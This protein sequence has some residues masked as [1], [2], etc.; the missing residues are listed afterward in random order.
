ML[1][2]TRDGSLYVSRF[3]KCGVAKPR[4]VVK[5]RYLPSGERLGRDSA[6]D[7]LTLGPRFAAVI[8]PA[9]LFL[10]MYRSPLG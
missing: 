8:Q 1:R 6:A 4:S 10:L 2:I 3:C 9:G 7:V 5:N